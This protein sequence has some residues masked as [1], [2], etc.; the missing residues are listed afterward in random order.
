V[1]R[2][3]ATAAV[4]IAGVWVGVFLP[5][6]VFA[7]ERLHLEDLGDEQLASTTLQR[8]GAPTEPLRAHLMLSGGGDARLGAASGSAA[9]LATGLGFGA[10]ASPT[11]FLQFYSEAIVPDASSLPGGTTWRDVEGFHRLRANYGFGELESKEAGVD[12]E[13]DAS[14]AHATAVSTTLLRPDVGPHPFWE[15]NASATV[16]PRI[17]KDHDEAFVVPVTVG[18][19]RLELDAGDGL[20]GFTSHRVSSGIGLRDYAK[21]T[22]SGWF[23][24]VG[25][26]WEQARFD[27]SPILAQANKLDVYGLRFEHWITSQDSDMALL[28]D[29]SIGGAWVWDPATQQQTSTFAFRL[30]MAMKMDIDHEESPRDH[31]L[32]GVAIARDAGWLADGSGLT[33]QWR[34]E[35]PLRVSLMDDRV[36]GSLRVATENVDVQIGDPTG[37][38]GWR[39]TVATEWYLAPMRGLQ[40]GAHHASTNACF[41][42]GDQWCHT[43][44]LFVRLTGDWARVTPEEGKPDEPETAPPDSDDPADVPDAPAPR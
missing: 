10:W 14:L 13:V 32:A 21:H 19:R 2:S 25:I 8:E 43:L 23:E 17:G 5:S 35:A 44:G 34:L 22:A 37:R 9:T 40:L 15:G 30:G 1:K 4:A 27:A 20:R 18:A 26:A 41:A 24:V 29:T 12:V 42:G 31:V 36:G 16:W 39:A 38:D 11:E 3:N 6:R 33:R 28:A 7:Q